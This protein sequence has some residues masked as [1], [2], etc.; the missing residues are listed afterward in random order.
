VTF[1]LHRADAHGR[2]ATRGDDPRTWDAIRRQRQAPDPALVHRDLSESVHFQYIQQHVSRPARILEG[3]CG[4]AKWVWFLEQ[5]GY[6]VYGVDFPESAIHNS[7]AVW[8]DLKLTLARLQEMPYEDGFFDGILSL[9][10]IEHD[11]NGPQ[12]ILKEFLRVLKPG[13]VLYCTV[14]CINGL[15]RAGVLSLQEFAHCN[16]LIRRARGRSPDVEFFEYYFSAREYAR[17]LRRAGFEVIQLVPQTPDPYLLGSKAGGLRS[18]L[19]WRIHRIW[20]WMMTHMV[21]AVCRRPL[22]PSA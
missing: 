14:P 22:V 19:V 3:G 2:G 20:P 21:G 17:V 18:R 13:G 9:G 8:P 1:A 5:C 10:T 16:R 6:E 7:H 15:R 11:M 4:F 12:M